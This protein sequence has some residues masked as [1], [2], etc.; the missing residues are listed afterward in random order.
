MSGSLR[1][2]TALVTGASSGIGL[3][4]AEALAA[5][6]ASVAMVAR[7]VEPLAAAAERIGGHAISGDVTSSDDV[8]RIRSTFARTLSGAPDI[9]VNAAGFFSIDSLVETST[10]AFDRSLSANVRGP[11]LILRALLPEMKERGS[12]HIVN[13]GSIAGRL[14]FPGNGAYSASKFALRGL[15]E[16]LA[17]ELASSG[18]KTTLVE[19]ASTDTSLWD[20]LDPDSRDDL[21]DRAV[22]LR[23]ADVARSIAFVVQQPAGVEISHLALRSVL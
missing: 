4:T 21:P 12:G 19:P 15:H 23:A 16:V 22:M 1:G 7:R 8:K 13:V 18:V 20:E 11:F 6:G 17:A 5:E 2:L 9:L 14:A 10:D 3:A